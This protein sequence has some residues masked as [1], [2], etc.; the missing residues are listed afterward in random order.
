MWY[1]TRVWGSEERHVKTWKEQL[2]PRC[3]AATD[4]YEWKK[5]DLF[6]SDIAH[7]LETMKYEVWNKIMKVE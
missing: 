4:I 5:Y 2:R 3:S 7:H 6:H 1:V